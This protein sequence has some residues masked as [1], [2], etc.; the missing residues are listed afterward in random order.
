VLTGP[1]RWPLNRGVFRKRARAADRT[2]GRPPW[3]RARRLHPTP[4]RPAISDVP[5]DPFPA[6]RGRGTKGKFRTNSW[7]GKSGS[8]R[9]ATR[10]ALVVDEAEAGIV[11]GRG[12]R[13]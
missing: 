13:N 12:H 1:S 3:G 10:C 7:T 8:G 2:E 6:D 11:L 5:G 9:A 4:D